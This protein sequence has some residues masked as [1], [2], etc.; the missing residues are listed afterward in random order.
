MSFKTTNIDMCDN[1]LEMYFYE[2]II[3]PSS[4]V[5]SFIN[6]LESDI[7]EADLEYDPYG[8]W[9]TVDIYCKDYMATVG[10]K[11][12]TDLIQDHLKYLKGVLP[13]DYFYTT[14]VWSPREY[15]FQSDALDVWP[16]WNDAT[17]FEK[18]IEEAISSDVVEFESFIK[19]YSSRDGFASFYPDTIQ[20]VRNTTDEKKSVILCEFHLHMAYKNG[21]LDKVDI[22]EVYEVASSIDIYEFLT[23]DS[24]AICDKIWDDRLL[25]KN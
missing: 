22:D 16:M 9:D 7:T 12:Y 1:G 23:D 18:L 5:N 6:G 8:L 3:S 2:S 19:K 13:I 11:V 14:G 10:R 21:A 20:G 4:M 25:A 17:N 15:N 24:K